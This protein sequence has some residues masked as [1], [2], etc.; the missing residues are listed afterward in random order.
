MGSS[1]MGR[2]MSSGDGWT[3]C[4]AGH[5]HWGLFGAAGLLVTGRTA[6]G[7]TEVG[8]QHRAPWTHEGDSWGVPGGARDRD[9]DAVTA[10]LREAKE[11]ADLDPSDVDPLG[12]YIDDHVGWSYTTVV[13]RP[14]RTL[15]PVA[16]NTES[17]SMRWH[18]VATVDRLPLHRGFAAT[19]THLKDV[20]PPLYLIV[21]SVAGSDPLLSQLPRSGVSA[22]RLPDGVRGGGLSRL[23]PRIVRVGDAEDAAAVADAHTSRGQVLLVRGREELS[24]LV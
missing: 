10:A 24:R 6:A 12:L 13:A 20:P 1:M 3:T 22:Q 14:T 15:T 8:L 4:G 7:V 17:L 5:R 2:Q 9:E 19:W 11:E 16:A 18:P 21:T 23:L